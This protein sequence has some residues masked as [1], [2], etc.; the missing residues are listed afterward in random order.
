MIERRVRQIPVAVERRK[1]GRPPLSDEEKAM[2]PKP[3]HVRLDPR[4]DDEFCAL[5]TRHGIFIN[6]LLKLA[7]QRL[8]A[9][10]RRGAL[11]L[12]EFPVDEQITRSQSPTE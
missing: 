12:S 5:S 11:D 7:A 4:T 1:V 10:A 2:Q 9:D 6:A 8:V 3:R